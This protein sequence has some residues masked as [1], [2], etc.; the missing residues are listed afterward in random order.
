MLHANSKNERL[1]CY[2]HTLH[3]TVSDGLGES[4]FLSAAIAKTTKLSSHLHQISGFKDMFEAAFGKKQGYSCR[5]Q[6]EMEL[7]TTANSGCAVTR[8]EDAVHVT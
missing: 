7:H 4:K 6:Y 5:R 3:L 8:S 1:S 2:C